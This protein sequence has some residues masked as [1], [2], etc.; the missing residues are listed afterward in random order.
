MDEQIIIDN[1][2]GNLN[3]RLNQPD[4]LTVSKTNSNGIEEVLR[5]IVIPLTGARL[6]SLNIYQIEGVVGGS[7]AT[8]GSLK[9]L[10]YSRDDDRQYTE[11]RVVLATRK[12]IVL[13]NNHRIPK[14]R[15]ELELNSD[16]TSREDYQLKGWDSIGVIPGEFE[17]RE[18]HE[19]GM[20]AIPKEWILKP[21][22]P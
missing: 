7:F 5:R 19:I 11:Q 6:D 14:M 15:M 20:R 9:F 17:I 2:L 10:N 3:G 21:Y 12:P 1:I 13:A 4:N 18:E 8:I 16:G 22:S